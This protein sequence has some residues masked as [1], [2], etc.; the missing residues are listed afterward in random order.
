[1]TSASPPPTEVLTA[2]G[3]GD[4]APAQLPGGEGKAWRVADHV[5]KRERQPNEVIAWMASSV[6]AVPDGEGFRMARHIAATD[7]R[8]LVDGWTA[9][10]WIDGAHASE[11]W[12]ERLAAS[13][14]FHTAIS[15]VELPPADL[16]WADTWWRTAD[17]VAWNEADYT[18]PANVQALI[19]RLK[20]LLDAPWSGAP[21]QIIHGDVAGNV[22]FADDGPPA[23][24]D[25]SLSVH[26]A[27]YSSAIAIADF[28]AWEGAPLTLAI[29]F[30]ATVDGADQLLAR[31]VVF[32]LVTAAEAF[33]DLPERIAAEVAAYQPVLSGIHTSL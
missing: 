3:V 1:M 14:A 31:A 11:R 12:D 10:R 25:L 2:F 32:R 28:I 13:R 22:L 18:A 8:F 23:L 15:G 19:D 33:R 6:E 27:E 26:P 30:S 17:R 9:T 16:P 7:G 5:L 4:A 20:P 29:R 24:I 21:V